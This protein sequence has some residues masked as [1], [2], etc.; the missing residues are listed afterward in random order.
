MHVKAH[1]P[2]PGTSKHAINGSCYR[3]VYHIQLWNFISKIFWDPSHFIISVLFCFVFIT[4][5]FI[6][7]NTDFGVRKSQPGFEFPALLLTSHVIMANVV[8]LPEP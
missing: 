1:S 5:H 8:S 6:E 2:I 4:Q 3:N 7:K